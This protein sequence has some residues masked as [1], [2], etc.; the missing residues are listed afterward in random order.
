L[1]WAYAFTPHCIAHA[2]TSAGEAA[3]ADETVTQLE[4]LVVMCRIS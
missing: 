1:I 4:A 3:A 2:R